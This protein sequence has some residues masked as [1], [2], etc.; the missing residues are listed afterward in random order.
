MTDRPTCIAASNNVL[1]LLM[2]LY[3]QYSNTV[4]LLVLSLSLPLLQA[5]ERKEE[6]AN[7]KKMAVKIS[8]RIK[9]TDVTDDDWPV[10]KKISEFPTQ[11][12]IPILTVDANMTTEEVVSK[13]Q[14]EIKRG[15]PCIIRPKKGKSILKLL[16]VLRQRH[17]VLFLH[18]DQGREGNQG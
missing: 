9:S 1:L 11:R 14:T 12:R 3:Y 2:L 6:D 5:A 13:A 16:Q 7:S 10:I 8:A 17:H 15:T 18:I 4:T